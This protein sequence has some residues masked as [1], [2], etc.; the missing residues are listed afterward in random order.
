[1]KKNLRLLIIQCEFEV[2]FDNSKGSLIFYFYFF[3][4]KLPGLLFSPFK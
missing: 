1:M 3:I 4:F 2:F